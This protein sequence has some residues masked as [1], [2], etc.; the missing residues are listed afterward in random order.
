[1]CGRYYEVKKNYTFLH[2]VIV[3]SNALY[4]LYRAIVAVLHICTVKQNATH[5]YE[6]NRTITTCQQCVIGHY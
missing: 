5:H 1:M 3:M 4:H 6:N 2:L